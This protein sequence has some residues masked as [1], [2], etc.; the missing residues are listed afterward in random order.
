MRE[1]DLESP[2]LA[3][4]FVMAF[5]MEPARSYSWTPFD[6]SN[7]QEIAR[8]HG[9]DYSS[10]APDYDDESYKDR[11]TWNQPPPDEGPGGFGG[12]HSIW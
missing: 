2:D 3:D 4:A 8:R 5:G 6:D 9:W 11:R 1:R 12:V 10:N 7:R